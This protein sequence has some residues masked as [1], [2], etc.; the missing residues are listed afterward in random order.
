[1]KSHLNRWILATA[2]VLM[3]AGQLS[4]AT[5]TASASF[6]GGDGWRSPGEVLAGDTLGTGPGGIYSYLGTGSLERGLAYNSTTSNLILV[7]RS[8]A[9]NGIRVLNGATGAD[10]GSLNQGS[11]VITGGTF[12]TSTVGVA[13][14]GAI[15]VANLQ[16]NVS[17]GAFKVYQWTNEAA[18]APTTFFNSTIPG[19]AGTPRN[20]DSLDVFGAGAGTTIVAGTSGAVGYSL[21][22]SSGA[23]A[24]TS[25]VPAGPA[26]GDFRLGVTF[27]G[28][29]NDVWG[30]QTGASPAAA[31]LRLT[32]YLGAAGTGLGSG[33]LT[34]GGEMAMDYAVVGGVPVLAVV[35]ANNSTLRVYDV[36]T[37]TAPVLLVSGTTTS[38]VL[39]GNGNAVGS[40]KFGAIS[41]T[42]ATIYAM[43]TNQGIQSFELR[44]VGIPEPTSA[45]LLSFAGVSLTWLRRRT[46]C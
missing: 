21:I 32:S 13:D 41:G 20:G 39:A 2:V 36:T 38:G 8:T 23:T 4:A 25:F 26:T 43:S 12:T 3:A 16:T 14:D 45:M 10:V 19:Y 24:V 27:A 9:G 15:Y 30:K 42:G 18:A 1:M 35:D 34:S 29:A 31:P 5:L 6:G 40:V 28:S 44:G 33:T 22:T 11:G 46:C 17:S 7:S 37:P